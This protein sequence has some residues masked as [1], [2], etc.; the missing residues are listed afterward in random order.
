MISVVIIQGPSPAEL[1][2]L[3]KS[4]LAPSY[5]PLYTEPLIIHNGKMQ[6]L[7]DHTGRK[8]LD[9]F[10]G[11]VTVSVGH[12]HPHVLAAVEKQ[13]RE[14]W[15]TTVIYMH[16]SMSQYAEKLVSKLPGDLEVSAFNM[17]VSHGSFIHRSRVS[18][19]WRFSLIRDQRQ[20]IWPQCWHAFPPVTL[21]Y[22]PCKIAITA[23]HRIHKA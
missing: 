20:M 13:M 17:Y 1:K 2:A 11:I 18:F 3:K 12:C 4:H 15:H 19:R 14:L 21:S 5:K 10:A 7:F 8:Y 23:S 6:W 22:C 16:P 9:M